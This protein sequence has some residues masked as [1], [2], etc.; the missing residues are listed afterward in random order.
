MAPAY[1]FFSH[2]NAYKIKS[3]LCLLTVGKIDPSSLLMWDKRWYNRDK[4]HAMFDIMT[5]QIIGL[6]RFSTFAKLACETAIQNFK[7]L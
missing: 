3:S 2:T 7:G 4:L 6:C 5:F 1:V